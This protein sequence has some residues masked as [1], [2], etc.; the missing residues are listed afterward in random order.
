NAAA[1]NV[2]F[3]PP[4]GVTLRHYCGATSHN[5]GSGNTLHAPVDGA[6]TSHCYFYPRALSY[7]YFPYAVEFTKFTA[8]VAT[9]ADQK[10]PFSPG[11]SMDRVYTMTT[12][13][14]NQNLT[15]ASGNQV[16]KYK[17]G[18]ER[19]LITDINNPAGAASAQST[20]FIGA[21]YMYGRYGYTSPSAGSG[22]DQRLNHVPG[23]VNMLFADGHV[24]FVKYPQEANSKYW[25]VSKECNFYF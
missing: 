5:D 2:G 20:I 25:Y 6:D 9:V 16:L 3:T 19:F 14:Y 1:K 18:V 8:V 7:C 21:D 10:I 22:R 11:E 12:G 13:E 4:G 23:G 15:C 24:E 17:E